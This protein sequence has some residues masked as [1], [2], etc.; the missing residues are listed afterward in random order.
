MRLVGR[1]FSEAEEVGAG[2]E[3][4]RKVAG[5]EDERMAGDGEFESEDAIAVR[6]LMHELHGLDVAERVGV[7]GGE[8]AVCA[9]HV[10]PAPHVVQPEQHHDATDRLQ[11]VLSDVCCGSAPRIA[12]YVQR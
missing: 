9:E 3:Q 2:E 10:H 5:D 6:A 1:A 8:V 7:V 11:A 12:L 4:E